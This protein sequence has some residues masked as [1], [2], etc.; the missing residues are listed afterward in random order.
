MALNRSHRICAG[1]RGQGWE[2]GEQP[3]DSP[4]GSSRAKA[5]EGMC[6]MDN[7]HS[8]YFRSAILLPV[9]NLKYSI[10]RDHANKGYPTEEL[11]PPDGYYVSI[12]MCIEPSDSP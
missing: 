6:A 7:I 12:C 11:Q 10:S 1:G 8:V 9:A 2:D 4:K 5:G 3:K